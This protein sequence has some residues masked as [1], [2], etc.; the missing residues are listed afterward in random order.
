M[1]LK[2]LKYWY[3]KGVS[4]VRKGCLYQ[5]SGVVFLP[6]KDESSAY[7]HLFKFILL[8]SYRKQRKT[9]RYDTEKYTIHF[10][11]FIYSCCMFN[12]R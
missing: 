1:S 7:R 12:G 8:L 2:S 6:L 4:I 9:Y 3:N 5:S 11:L 10:K